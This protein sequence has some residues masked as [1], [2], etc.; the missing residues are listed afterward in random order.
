MVTQEE[1]EIIRH[2]ANWNAIIVIILFIII[3]YLFLALIILW[4][5][6]IPI[7]M[8]VEFLIQKYHYHNP[9]ISWE[10]ITKLSLIGPYYLIFVPF[11]IYYWKFF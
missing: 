4:P 11:R 3:T 1:F 2:D 8:I 6:F 7:N 9:R 10:A 5:L